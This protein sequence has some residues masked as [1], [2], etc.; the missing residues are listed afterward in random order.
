MKRFGIRKT[1]FTI[2]F[3]CSTAT[4][5]LANE[6]KVPLSNGEVEGEEAKNIFVSGEV[7][8]MALFDSFFKETFNSE[9]GFIY[10]VKY[11]GEIFY[12]YNYNLSEWF[13]ERF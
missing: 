13:C 7:V 2:M 5:S 12:C 9:V 1:L 6:V 11:Q 3:L 10:T 8:G 4:A